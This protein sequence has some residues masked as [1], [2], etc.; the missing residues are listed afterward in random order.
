M[1]IFKKK[2]FRRSSPIKYPKKPKISSKSREGQKS[3]KVYCNLKRFNF[4]NDIK[5]KH[6]MQYSIQYE[7]PIS[8][9]NY[10]LKRTIIRQLREDLEGNFEKYFQAGDT[11][12]I[13]SNDSIEKLSL[14]TR[15]KEILYKVTFVKTSNFIDCSK[16][17][18]RTY[19]NLKIKGFLE[20]MIRNIIFSNI[21]LQFV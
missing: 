6:I 18:T 13:C 10:P 9:D 15:I 21:Q 2:V 7:P 1:E 12:Y 19:E 8:E 5:N 11:L 17:T 20:S 4:S 14:E 3:L 16:I